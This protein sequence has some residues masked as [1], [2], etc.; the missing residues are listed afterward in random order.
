MFN[1]NCSVFINV[2]SYLHS[3]ATSPM[4]YSTRNQ[5]GYGHARLR[6]ASFTYIS[7]MFCSHS[8]LMST[9]CAEYCFGNT[10]S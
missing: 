8:T 4:A 1:F 5:E 6:A 3:T 9:F 2:I 7:R 10:S